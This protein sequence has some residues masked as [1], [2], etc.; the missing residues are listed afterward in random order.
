MS[1]KSGAAYLAWCRFRLMNHYWPRVQRCLVELS[2]E[3]IWWREHESNNSAGNLVL[4]LVGN[5][6]QFVLT[7]FG[8]APDTRDK[9]KE[10]SGRDSVAKEELL[11]R[12][13]TALRESDAI[14]SQFN[15]ERFQETTILQG[16]ERTYLEIL[17]IVL[18]HFALHTGQIIF[19][20]K[21]KTGKD[22]TF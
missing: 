14:L 11:R 17:S 2:D 6:N 16:R 15:P 13:E 22:L 10:F 19:I 4:H 5:L 20:A 7:A 12:L 1:E 9:E 8:G 3:Q 21:L 18:E